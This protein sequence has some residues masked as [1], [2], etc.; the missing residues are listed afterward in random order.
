MVRKLRAASEDF[1]SWTLSPPLKLYFRLAGQIILGGSHIYVI[2]LSVREDPLHGEFMGRGGGVESAGVF[3]QLL[4]AFPLFQ[5]VD[6]GPADVAADL[7]EGLGPAG[8]KDV[9]ILQGMGIGDWGF[10]L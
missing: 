4:D 3:Q 8:K 9:P 7:D 1:S 2:R 5:F 10:R 6:G